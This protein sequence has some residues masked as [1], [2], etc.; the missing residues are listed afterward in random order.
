VPK[1]LL[2]LALACLA[3]SAAAADD[4]VPP[5]SVPDLV[6]PRSLA[7]GAG[8]G[9][10]SANEALF[11]NPAALAARKRYVADTFFLSDRRAGL[12]PGTPSGWGRQDYLG[13]AV[14]DSSTTEVAAGLAYVRVMK[15][16]ETGTLLRLGAAATLSEGLSVGLQGNYFDLRGA[17]RVKSAVNLDAG[18]FYQVS[19]LVSVGASAYNLLNGDHRDTVMPR[20]FGVGFAAGSERSLQVV[21]D[22]RYDLDRTNPRG[23]TKT[24]RYSI[25][26]EYLYGGAVPL[27]AGYAVDD[28]TRTRWWS[29]GAGY[30][31]TR[32]AVDLAYR[33]SASD[34]DARTYGLAVRLF[35][36]SE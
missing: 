12:P 26:A 33:Q 3:G 24:H 31:T 18:L 25:G 23:K 30:V 17:T 36:P 32:F 13:G 35:V 15:G 5:L 4:P 11:L 28:T 1:R 34:P 9:M 16:V 22:W 10:A 7:L 27:R 19:P 20:G 21:G 2:I 29:A 8:V 14:V 6:G